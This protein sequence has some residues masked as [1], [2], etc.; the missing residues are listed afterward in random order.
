MPEHGA[1]RELQ[2]ALRQAQRRIAGAGSGGVGPKS[3]GAKGCTWEG[4]FF[5][6][7]GGAL[8]PLLR[9]PLLRHMLPAPL[10]LGM[11]RLHNR[12]A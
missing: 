9:A 7:G 5:R 3:C 2:E 1:N 6:G 11:Q 4:A 8:V 12:G 10:P